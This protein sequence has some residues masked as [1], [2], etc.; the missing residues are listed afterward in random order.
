MS[1]QQAS[2]SE[3]RVGNT[4][5]TSV[6]LV[7]LQTAIKTFSQ[8]VQNFDSQYKAMA[9]TAGHIVSCWT[10]AASASFEQALNNWMNDFYK[11]INVLNGMENALAENTGVLSQANESTIAAAQRAAAQIAAP[12]LPGF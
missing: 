3:V 7:G 5:M 8:G 4:S 10:G 9:S 12:P 2:I 6:D 11:V 1:G